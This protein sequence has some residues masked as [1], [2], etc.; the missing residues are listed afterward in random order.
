MLQEHYFS[1]KK[2]VGV[3]ANLPTNVFGVQWLIVPLLDDMGVI[4][5][6]VIE[7]AFFILFIFGVFS[8]FY[9]N[10]LFHLI[11]NV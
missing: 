11:K 5:Y 3:Q 9:G 2:T 7:N 6:V 4:I 10:T 8:F 1:Y